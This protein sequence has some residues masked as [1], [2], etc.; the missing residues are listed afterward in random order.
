MIQV[1][2]VLKGSQVTNA[3]NQV[4]LNKLAALEGSCCYKDRHY[5]VNRWS[6]LKMFLYLAV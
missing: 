6:A 2:D 1:E 3:E 5:K 4:F